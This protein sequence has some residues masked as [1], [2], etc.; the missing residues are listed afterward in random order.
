MDQHRAVGEL[1]GEVGEAVAVH[2][3]GLH[4]GDVSEPAG[5]L[6]VIAVFAA[7]HELQRA[8]E[9][10]V[11]VEPSVGV[12][13]GHPGAVEGTARHVGAIDHGGAGFADGHQQGAGVDEVGPGV[14]AHVGDRGQRSVR[15]TAV[16]HA[17]PADRGE[18]RQ[19]VGAAPRDLHRQRA[20]R[21]QEHVRPAV[22]IDVG[23]KSAAHARGAI[24]G[25]GQRGAQREGAVIVGAAQLEHADQGI[26]REREQD[27]FARGRVGRI[28]L[29]GPQLWHAAAIEPAHIVFESQRFGPHAE[30]DAALPPLDPPIITEFVA[31]NTD[32]LRDE[33][34]DTEDWIELY[35]PNARPLD[36]A[37]HRLTD[38]RD[39]LDRWVF[40]PYVMP[41]HSYL[42]V[43]ASNKDRT[44]PATGPLH[45]NFRLDGDGEY[46]ALIDPFGN[47]IQEFDGW[48]PQPPDVSWGLPMDVER[49]PL[50]D[51]GD[52]AR[53]RAPGAGG[54]WLA[55]DYDDADWT[56]VVLGVGFDHAEAPRPPF[57]LTD[58]TT[59]FGSEQGDGGWSY[60]YYD[61]TIDAD[62][63]YGIGDF[64]PFPHDGA[65]HSPTDFWNGTEWVWFDGN[66]PFT[67]L[68]A[69][70]G[71]PNGINHESTMWA[72]RRFQ[73]PVE[74][75]FVIEGVLR[76]PTA[77]GDGVA[78]RILV[79]GVEVYS[80]A[81]NFD[82]VDYAIEVDL[83]EGTI[84][85]FALDPLADDVG[86]GS[87]F[88]A[89]IGIPG[90]EATPDALGPLIADT[91]ADWSPTGEQ[92][93]RGWL[94]GYFN[95]S[96]D[97]DGTYSPDEFTPFPRDGGGWSPTDFWSGSAWDWFQ[98][99]PPWTL[100]AQD[101]VHPNGIN[102]G[103]EHWA[104][105]RFVTPVGGTLLLEWHLAKQNPNGGGVTGRIFVEGVEMDRAAIAGNDAVGVTRLIAL[106]D[107][108]PG[109]RI[110]I[111]HE[112]TGPDGNRNDG[113]DGS[114]MSARIWA[115][116]DLDPFIMTD[117]GPL[118]DGLPGLWLR[119][120]FFVDDPEA[121]DRLTLSLRFDDGVSAFVNGGPVAAINVPPVFDPAAT[122]LEDRPAGEAL[123]PVDVPV[124][125]ALLQPGRNVLALYALDAAADDGRF[126][127]APSLIASHATL[128]PDRTRL[129][130]V[131]TPGA[132]NLA[133]PNT[134][135]VVYDLTRDPEVA[136]DDVVTVTVRVA[137]SAAPVAEVT[138]YARQR[139]QPE[140][141]L[142]MEPVPDAP[143]QYMATL[144]AEWSQPGELLR[145]RAVA[146]D[147]E[148]RIA[149][150]P[151]FLDP[152][153]SEQYLGTV[154]E[155]PV[156][157][158]DLP[159]LHWFIEQ[160]DLANREGG[161]R[162]TL[163]FNGEL[164]DNVLTDLHGQ[165]TRGFPKC[166][167]GYKG[168]VGIYQVMPV[169][170]TIGRIIMEG[171]NAIQIADQARK[172]GIPDLRRSGLKKVR[173][174]LT[175][176]EEV[177]R[178]T[179]D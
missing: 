176:L 100:I 74:G 148:G 149:R 161:T 91:I 32:G 135:P 4:L 106:P 109:D 22:Q 97:A 164:Y 113:S 37:G 146:A 138:L 154:V 168:R 79:D 144:P 17:Q 34:G 43:F 116:A 18:R 63:A 53:A 20:L 68:D 75:H 87:L 159:V 16:A 5:A 98:G 60:G 96:A 82:R 179:K 160:P 70:G 152:L 157:D 102:N 111:V 166:T 19:P 156:I 121:V 10:A 3:A 90:V 81:V 42:V 119:A 165:S 88:T 25:D 38:D 107:V 123:H 84:I 108:R 172:E 11:D 2:V 155:N 89:S 151:T 85:D 27:L 45:T 58:S 122:A 52:L 86:D 177:N 167:G 24:V 14:T 158:S 48:P 178:V 71:T 30:V 174:G 36:L 66:P 65:G 105:R 142:P 78:G 140:V 141:A 8:G 118:R 29:N 129:F 47:I 9:Q 49:I 35:N 132:D 163:W 171:G 170:D 127:I 55:P 124:D 28:E 67:R 31:R 115:P 64:T 83:L 46:L 112:P 56:E 61:A 153:D 125:T 134:G 92:G 50:L 175:S 54:A 94:Y 103:A 128:V 139:F 95:L 7:Q 110:D 150:E 80:A 104:I 26:F 147:A 145:W 99:N 39:I 62:G 15:S 13:I 40:P 143:G 117:A 72:V 114:F 131:P 173:D 21:Q 69:T 130:P 101:Q 51:A 57:T 169:S 44:D 120:P 23:D 6:Q 133:D 33:D 76:N 93:Y 41:P 1:D 59:A 162:S 73:S 136:P 12:Q 126:L 77:E 137:E